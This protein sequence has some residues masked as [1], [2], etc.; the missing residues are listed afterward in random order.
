MDDI[1]QGLIKRF[2][3][4]D[5]F[6]IAERLN[7]HIRYCNLGNSTRGFYYRKLRRRF[8]VIHDGLNDPWKRFVC[9][10]ELAHDRLHPGISRFYID[11]QSFFSAGKFERQ[12][13]LFAVKL[14]MSNTSADPGETKKQLLQRCSIPIEL[15]KYL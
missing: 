8:I 14:L 13:N 12:A 9:A 1:V 10:H 4:N 2:K 3:T 5:P 6:I 7:I 11:E 15:H